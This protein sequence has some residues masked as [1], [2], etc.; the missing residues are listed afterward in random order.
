MLDVSGNSSHGSSGRLVDVLHD[1]GYM[2]HRCVQSCHRVNCKC[3]R[4]TV[5]ESN[6]YGYRT[7][8]HLFESVREL[9]ASSRI[10]C[11]VCKLNPIN[12]LNY[13]YKKG[14]DFT[15]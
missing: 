6:L 8:N 5:E 10:Y 7:M 13:C 4:G 14:P 2:I 11:Q 3:D 9:I 15:G 1:Q 12:V